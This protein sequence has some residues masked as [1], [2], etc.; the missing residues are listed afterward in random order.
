MALKMKEEV[1]D[2]QVEVEQQRQRAPLIRR[3]E[4]I[5]LTVSLVLIDFITISGAFILAYYLRLNT[6]IA[7]IFVTPSAQNYILMLGILIVTTMIVFQVYHLYDLGRSRSRIDEF[8]KIAAAVTIGSVL[9]IAINSFF[10]ADQ[11]VY[12]RQV[13]VTGWFGS[14]VLVTVARLLYGILVARLRKKGFAQQRV[15]IVGAGDTGQML[16]D[17]IQHEPSKSYRVSGFLD[18]ERRGPVNGVPVIGGTEDIS[19]IIRWRQ[20]DEVI[21]CVEGASHQQILE[22]ILACEDEAVSIRVLPD[23]F[24]IIA[25]NQIGVGDLGGLPLINVRDIR[26]KGINRVLKRIV[27]VIFSAVVLVIASPVLMLVALLI[28]LTSPGPVFYVQERV[29]LDGLPIQVIKFRSMRVGAEKET[30]PVWAKPDDPRRTRF[31]A[32]I[33]RFS[34]DELP[35]FINVLLGN[36]SI[37]GP[38][39]ERPHFV[40]QFSQTIPRYMRRHREKAGLTGWAQVNG[41]RGDTS[42]EERTRY[43]LYYIENWSLLFDFKIMARTIVAI[44]RDQNA[45]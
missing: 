12:S 15:L 10:L 30:G 26:L 34:I 29:G 2:G 21:Y 4:D 22:F 5:I 32:F 27:D 37:V 40:E 39:P 1:L 31:G 9:S 23:A 13:M 36:M 20:V 24:Q 6:E 44:F 43:D 28:K 14:I 42:I 38:R 35:Q 33:R 41:L 16:L 7:G 17:K 45:Y 18:D 25:N 11:F 8:Y 19:K 3:K